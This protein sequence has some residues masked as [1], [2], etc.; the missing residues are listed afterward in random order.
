MSMKPKINKYISIIW[1]NM[2]KHNIHMCRLQNKELIR[3][4]KY[5][6]LSFKTTLEAS[7]PDGQYCLGSREPD[8]E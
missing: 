1:S 8:K 6:L 3:Q 7:L 5:L 4:N 2:N